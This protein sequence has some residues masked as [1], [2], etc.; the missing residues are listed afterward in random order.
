MSPKSSTNIR[1]KIG[2]RC[3]YFGD[4]K[5]TTLKTALASSE[6]SALCKV[7]LS[8]CVDR[9]EADTLTKDWGWGRLT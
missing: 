6:P 3:F 1:Q 8:L 9:W 7:G 2:E 4:E 5:L